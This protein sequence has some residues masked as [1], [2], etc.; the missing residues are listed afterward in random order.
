MGSSGVGA[1]SS[2]GVAPPRSSIELIATREC[3]ASRLIP[4]KEREKEA[5]GIT[6]TANGHCCVGQSPGAVDL[7]VRARIRSGGPVRRTRRRDEPSVG[8]GPEVVEAPAEVLDEGVPAD[9]HLRGPV[10]L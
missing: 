2:D 6:E 7:S 9:D 1:R 8:I 3:R 10:T 4:A 5:M